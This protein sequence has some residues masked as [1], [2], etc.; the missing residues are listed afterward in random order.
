MFKAV[1]AELGIAFAIV[2]I[3][4]PEAILRER[5]V[6]RMQ[7]GKDASDAGIAV[8]EHQLRT[9]EPLASD[10]LADGFVYE[11]AATDGAPS[12]PDWRDLV[13]YLERSR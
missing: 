1:A 7:D 5:V 9:A 2:S 4:A 6:R 13:E 11:A 3:S 12:T 10:E 8:L